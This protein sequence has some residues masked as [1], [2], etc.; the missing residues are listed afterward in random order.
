MIRTLQDEVILTGLQKISKWQKRPICTFQIPDLRNIRMEVY[1]MDKHADTGTTLIHNMQVHKVMDGR[2][3]RVLGRLLLL[4]PTG[5][6][7]RIIKD[8]GKGVGV[9]LCDLTY[10]YDQ[11]WTYNECM[12]VTLEL[13]MHRRSDVRYTDIF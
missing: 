5:E 4:S 2:W 12:T 7:R 3:T 8:T 10:C 1:T 13:Y 11:F 9:L 6:A